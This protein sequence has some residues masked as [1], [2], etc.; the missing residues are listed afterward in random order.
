M[1]AAGAAVAGE[2][3]LVCHGY[4]CQAQDEVRYSEGQLGEIRRLLFAADDAGGE[5][6]HLAVALGTLYGWAGQQ[7]DIRNDKGGNFADEGVP[8][9]MDCIDHSTTTTRLLQLLEARGY[10]RWHRVGE[11]AMRTVAL[12]FAPHR[13]A[14]IETL[15]DGEV[16]AFAVDSWFVD[17]GEP[18]VI[19]PLA[20][21]KKGA[22]PDV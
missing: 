22:G 19:L 18:A 7:S 3:L 21:W 4:G 20:D 10:L 11:P 6:E 16:Q 17:N 13:S 5:R 8:G 15:G 14:V 12:V 2:R 1:A 9:R